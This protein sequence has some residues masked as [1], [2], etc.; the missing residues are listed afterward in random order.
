LKVVLQTIWEELPQEHINKAMANFNCSSYMAVTANDGHSEQ[1]R[2]SAVLTLS[3]SKFAS[4]YL[5][6]NKNDSFHS[7]Q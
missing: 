4:T 6:T 5:I 2:A 3:F 1:L 7:R